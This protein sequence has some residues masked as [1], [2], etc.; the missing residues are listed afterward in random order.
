MT[1]NAEQKARPVSQWF[2]QAKDKVELTATVRSDTAVEGNYGV[3]H[4][5]AFTT[6]EGNSLIWWTSSDQQLKVGSNVAVCGTIKGHEEYREVKSTVLT[7][8]KV[9]DLEAETQREA[10]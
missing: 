3:R 9:A 6:P 4:R 7:R 2:G 1:R 10:G 8:C 5:Y